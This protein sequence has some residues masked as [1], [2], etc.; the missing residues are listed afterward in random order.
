MALL[1]GRV[2]YPGDTGWDAARQGFAR[3]ADYAANTPRVVVFCQDADD[4]ANAV[5]WARENNAPLRVRCG[6]HNYE[7]WSSLVQDGVI[8]DVS[9]LGSVRVR[10]DSATA[11]VGA[12]L[13]MLDLSEALGQVGVTFPHATGKTVGLAGLTLGGGFGVTTRKWGLTCDNLIEVE[14]VTADGSQVRA[15]AEE[16]PDLFWACRGGGG[17]NFGIATA[18][19]FS[20]HPAGNVAVFSLSWPW[21]AMEAVVSAWQ[22][23]AP[24][25]VDGV[26]SFLTL[27]TTRS[28]TMQG[29]FTPD[30]D[31]DLPGINALLAP[32]LAAANPLSVNI[33]VLPN[34]NAARL[35]LGV[36]PQQPEWRVQKH[37]DDQIF[38]SSSALAYEPFPPQAITLLKSR[39][40]ACP[41]LS[42]A[43]SQPSM[44][45]LLGGGG[46]MGRV[47]QDATA[48]WHRQTKFVVQYD[49]YWTAPQDGKMTLDWITAFRQDMTPYTVGAYVNYADDRLENPLQ[50]YYGDHLGRLMDIKRCWDPDNVFRFPQSI[51]VSPP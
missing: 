34:L 24:D 39:I 40:E 48:V 26:T 12:G 28:L 32:M 35:F 16:N 3:W 29:Q 30:T 22:S 18:F 9:D 4:V 41:T 1:T 31:A 45:Q 47:P 25:T 27:L 38:K 43:P 19:T 36:D 23:W 8:I 13:D 7:G 42:A 2:I 51:P 14:L 6:R 11:R 21:E 33:Q 37:S 20:V 44:I 50:Q 17:G 10:R 5:R 46:A 15:N 49:A